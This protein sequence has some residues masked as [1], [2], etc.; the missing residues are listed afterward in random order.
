[1][2]ELPQVEAEDW[3]DVKAGAE[4]KSVPKSRMWSRTK[5][6]NVGE[7]GSQGQEGG[8]EV[9]GQKLDAS[10]D[11]SPNDEGQW[12]RTGPDQKVVMGLAGQWR[13]LENAKFV[14]KQGD[15]RF[16]M[17]N[18]S[19]VAKRDLGAMYGWL[20][21]IIISCRSILPGQDS[22]RDIKLKT[23]AMLRKMLGP[24][25]ICGVNV[26]ETR[27]YRNLAKQCSSLFANV[28]GELIRQW[29][30]GDDE[31]K[32]YFP[33]S[34]LAFIL[35]YVNK[36]TGEN[37]KGDLNKCSEGNVSTWNTEAKG[38]KPFTCPKPLSRR[39]VERLDQ[40]NGGVVMCPHHCAEQILADCVYCHARQQQLVERAG[41]VCR[42]AQAKTSIHGVDK[43]YYPLLSAKEV[44]VKSWI[45]KSKR[46]WKVPVMVGLEGIRMEIPS[47]DALLA[48][49]RINLRE[50]LSYTILVACPDL[51][52]HD[53]NKDWT[54]MRCIDMLDKVH[55]GHKLIEGTIPA[56]VYTG[57]HLLHRT[58]VGRGPKGQSVH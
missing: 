37:D 29:A 48:R 10:G 22:F 5:L 35:D 43:V 1:M 50:R 16:L 7:G 2:A 26:E 47:P 45:A 58:R 27:I 20:K 36:P 19:E 57:D 28:A 42:K 33:S 38:S 15:R 12:E 34:N 13:A 25:G 18:I 11:D 55:T 39:D 31:D 51:M 53:V 56:C 8:E 4:S 17:Y 3:P 24:D 52:I 6:H 49:W 30:E 21:D 9:H 32:I 41:A 54:D 23:V 14:P 44:P 46:E 40:D